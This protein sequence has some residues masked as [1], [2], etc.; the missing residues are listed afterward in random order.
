MEFEIRSAAENVQP[1]I[2][3]LIENSSIFIMG[4]VCG[5]WIGKQYR[6]RIVTKPMVSK[7][8]GGISGRA[9]HEQVHTQRAARTGA[10]QQRRVVV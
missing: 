6:K 1:G 7:K 10:W 2:K 3:F 8:V 4:N 9:L 5:S